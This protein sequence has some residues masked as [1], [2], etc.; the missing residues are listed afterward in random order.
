MILSG[1]KVLLA[2]IFFW[3]QW[4]DLLHGL[5]YR[6]FVSYANTQR[7]VDWGM[8]ESAFGLTVET[9]LDGN[10]TCTAEWESS[11]Y[12]SASTELPAVSDTS[13]PTSA[14]TEN[15][16]VVAPSSSSG[17]NAIS[18]LVIATMSLISIL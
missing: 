2:L 11:Y 14:P 5:D 8:M 12:Q 4:D 6:V 13:T 16:I 9:F 7:E 3:Q 15:D 18:C 10:E 1:R 17:S